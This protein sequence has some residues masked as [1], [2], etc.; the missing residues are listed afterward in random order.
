MITGSPPP[1][2][3]AL[4]AVPAMIDI[5]RRSR[6][7]AFYRAY[8]RCYGSPDRSLRGTRFASTLPEG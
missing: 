1:P 3:S 5:D 7:Q 4:V 6:T 2:I 8:G